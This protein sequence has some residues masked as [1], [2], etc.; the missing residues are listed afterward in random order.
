[1][2]RTAET[3]DALAPLI[4]DLASEIA[5]ELRYQRLLEALRRLLPCDAIA[6]LHLEADV[7][8]PLAVH[9]LSPDTLGRRFLVN[10]HP[11]LQAILNAP[12]AIRFPAD[13]GLPDPY[14]GLVEGASGDLAVHDCIG[15]VLRVG[16]A[17][18][19]VL[20]LDALDAG[21][22]SAADLKIL[23]TFAGLA[24]ATVAA[25]ARLHL[26]TRSVEDERRKAEAHRLAA[27][28]I[29]HTLAGNSPAFR[30]LIS[31]I[32]LVAPSDLTVLITG[33]TGV[34]K[35][36]VARQLHAQS[37]RTAGVFVS[38]NCAAL[39][40][41][42]VESE[43]FGHVRG[44]FSGATGDRHGKF[45]M[46]HHG[47]LFLDEVG[48]LPLAAQAK[49]LRVLQDGQ[50]QRIG[51]DREH[52]ADVRLLA[53]TNRD[54]ASEVRAGR[55]RAD[56]YHRLSVYPL[57]VPPLRDRGQDVLLLAG[58]FIE[59]NRRRMGLRGLRLSANAQQ[60]LLAHAWPGNVRELEYLIARA[61]LKTMGRHV[62]ASTATLRSDILTLEVADLDIARSPAPGDSNGDGPHALDLEHVGPHTLDLRAEVDAFQRRLI[63]RT[64]G[65]HHSNLAAAARA[66]TIDR[67]NLARLISRL[68]LVTG[69]ST[70]E[71]RR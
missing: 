43:L 4:A 59:E 26:L 30:Q 45:E 2:T 38:V 71:K 34:G 7:L 49:L 9:G 42:L 48:E 53:A 46:A 61:A 6:L 15:C 24:C 3:L 56:L 50:L 55:I 52:H 17:T 67:A 44:A 70:K 35:E 14:D 41:N 11:R 62:R 22:F 10:A 8:V 36:L 57:H 1:M 65:Q 58:T 60:L 54:L 13:C 32:D 68:G 69:S 31:E 28:P 51:S 27:S 18:W 19:G 21:R 33:E 5:P 39:P 16:H 66:L 20:T 40:D 29:R 37:S 64:L 63:E 47:T 25:T 23:N 12:H